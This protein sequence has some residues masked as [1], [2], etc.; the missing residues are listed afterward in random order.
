MEMERSVNGVKEVV[1]HRDALHLNKRSIEFLLLEG[2]DLQPEAGQ[3][4][5]HPQLQGGQDTR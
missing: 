3:R 4:P 1:G 2:A 5:R